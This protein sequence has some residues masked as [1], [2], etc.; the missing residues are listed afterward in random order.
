M[1]SDIKTEDIPGFLIRLLAYPLGRFD[2]RVTRLAY[3][4]GY[5]SDWAAGMALRQR[6]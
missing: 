3:M 1:S 5:R 6:T 4:E 2:Q